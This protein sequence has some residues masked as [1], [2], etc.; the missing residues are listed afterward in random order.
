M[1][2]IKTKLVKRTAESLVKKDAPVSDSFEENKKI[3]GNTLPSKKIRNQVA[4]L[5]TRIK[6]QEKAK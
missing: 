4:G 1:G 6:K 5:L 2:K 3:L